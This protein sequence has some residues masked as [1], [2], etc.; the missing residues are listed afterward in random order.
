MQIK[1][2]AH[3]KVAPLLPD[4][5]QAAASSRVPRLHNT[6]KKRLITIARAN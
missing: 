4:A 6:T 5:S 1:D 2:N 3:P